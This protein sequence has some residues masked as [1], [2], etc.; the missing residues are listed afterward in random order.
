MKKMILGISILILFS[1]ML[2][3][4]SLAYVSFT[5]TKETIPSIVEPGEKAN[6][7]LTIRNS[8]TEVARN[9]KI[10]FSPNLY[11]TPDQYQYDIATIAAGS[12]QVLTV[13][14][15]ISGSAGEGTVALPFTIEYET[16]IG[17]ANT[18]ENSLS[19][20]ITRRIFIQVEDTTFNKAV[21]QPG[22]EVQ[23]TVTFKNIGKGI[24]KDLRA[25][26]ED[27]SL[28]FVYID[29]SKYL[30]NIGQDATFTATFN[31][32]VN[33]DAKTIAY[34]MPINISYYDESGVFHTDR[35]YV[36]VKISGKPEFVV[37]IDS[38]DNMYSGNIGKISVSIANRGTA[39]A[40]F[41]TLK[42]DSNLD[43]TPSEYYAGNLDPDDTSTV[44]LQVNLRGIETGRR[45]LN[46]SLM[47]KDPYNKDYS[48]VRTLDFEVTNQPIQVSGT[49][50]IIIVAVAIVI[51]YWKRNFIKGLIKRK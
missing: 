3:S 15:T 18:F 29:S 49:T 50:Q 39:S 28:P 27:Y 34:N 23:M 7:V 4:N 35:K 13:P 9:V 45:S 46:M 10:K 31:L 36:G 11:I 22:D 26:L 37:S 24:I 20:Q 44:S 16:D 32:I 51:L 25:S 12:S 48:E 19:I 2:A 1:L 43:I 41:L 5:V 42:F 40:Q 6:L 47:Y 17:G 21:V 33:K 38:T 14:V 30:G 8:G